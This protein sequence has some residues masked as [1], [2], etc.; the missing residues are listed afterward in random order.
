MSLGG[1]QGE[2]NAGD[3]EVVP[4]REED[5]AD[6]GGTLAKGRAVGWR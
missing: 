6:G 4:P 5:M 2:A 3:C 1:E